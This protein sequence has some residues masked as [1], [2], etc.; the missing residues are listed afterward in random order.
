M[1]DSRND[2]VDRLRRYLV[3]RYPSASISAFQF[4]AS[5]WESDV[6][7]F[8]LH[9]AAAPPRPL[10][11]RLFS[12]EG[13]IDKMVRESRG[14][15]RLHEVG[16][17]VPAMLLHETDPAV[18]GKPFTIM[19]KFEGRVLWPVLAEATLTRAGELLDRFGG[20]LARLHGLD[21]RPFTE[22]AAL[23]DARPTAILS[24]ML[25]AAR[26]LYTQFG[27]KG[28][29]AIVDWLERYQADITVRPAVVHLDFHANNVFL[30]PDDRMA[31]I[32]WTQVTVSDYRA[33][34]SWTL[35]IMGDFGRPQWG[36]SIL[37]AYE[38]EARQRVERLDYFNVIT[39]AKFLASTVISM[40]A[41][42]E[43][44]GLRPETVASARRQAPALHRLAGRLRDI[45]GITVPEVEVALHRIGA[46]RGGDDPLRAS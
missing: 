30:R 43:G 3:G 19:E 14:L 9:P 1:S 2:L 24:E 15:T 41:G 27:V 21:W 34:L 23:Y 36:D 35:M 5:G 31:V 37:R 25:A 17:P 33:D 8:T 10:I 40:R 22:H 39:Y 4:V 6:Y 11:L 45:T 29:M 20:L 42:P 26:G 7:A 32:D 46:D 38:I 12:G 44:L 28:F 16:Y 13:A 18:L